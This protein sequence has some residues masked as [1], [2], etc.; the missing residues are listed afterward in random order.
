MALGEHRVPGLLGATGIASMG[1]FTDE[2]VPTGQRTQ[3]GSGQGRQRVVRN[4]LPIADG[5]VGH[6][7]KSDAI[8]RVTFS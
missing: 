4:S 2:R 3:H 8:R 1:S 6:T 5:P 7:E